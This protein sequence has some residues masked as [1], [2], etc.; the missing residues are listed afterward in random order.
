MVMEIIGEKCWLGWIMKAVI[1]SKGNSRINLV[2]RKGWDKE[3]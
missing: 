3:I 1:E 2:Q